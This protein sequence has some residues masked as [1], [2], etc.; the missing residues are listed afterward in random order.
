[1]TGNIDRLTVHD[2]PDND[3][4]QFMRL[5]S[6]AYVQAGNADFEGECQ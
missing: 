2:L 5:I 4:P 6:S 1:M 3:K